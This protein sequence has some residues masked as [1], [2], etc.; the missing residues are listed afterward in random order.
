MVEG[1][2]DSL[3]P[4]EVEQPALDLTEEIGIEEFMK[5]DLRVA[6]ITSAS[7]VEGA[8]KLVRLTLDLGGQTRT[9][10][11]GI[12]TAYRPEELEGRLTVVVA[13]LASRKM[14]FG[15]SEG[16]VLAAGGGGKEIFLLHPDAGATPG[17]RIK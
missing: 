4:A 7:Q 12:R 2:R 11:A 3:K 13:N 15:V 1:S 6:R 5:V 10:F 14:R 8:D 17:M 16:M 9:V